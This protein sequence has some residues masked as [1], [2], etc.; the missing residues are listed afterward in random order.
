MKRLG[1]AVLAAGLL[2]GAPAFAADHAIEAGGNTVLISD[3]VDLGLQVGAGMNSYATELDK[4]TDPGLAWEVRGIYGARQLIGFELA[5]VGAANDLKVND[6]T[7]ARIMSQ[8][9]EALLRANFGLRNFGVHTFEGGDIIPYVAAGGAF[10]SMYAADNGGSQLDQV[11]G[12]SY[13]STSTFRIPA[14]VGVDAIVADHYTIGVRG[15]YNYE[16]ANDLRTDVAKTDVQSWQA[17]GHVGF[18]F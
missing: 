7:T 9:G 8:G 2:A 13:Q 1:M 6:G 15:N 18:A 14:A 3:K 10:G 11:A 16:F 4:G 5:Y 12:V 17:L